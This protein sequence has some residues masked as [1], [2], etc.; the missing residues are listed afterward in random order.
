MMSR[1]ITVVALVRVGLDPAAGFTAGLGDVL[2][3]AQTP[4]FG[5]SGCRVGNSPPGAPAGQTVSSRHC[6]GILDA[7]VK[8]SGLD[9]ECEWAAVIACDLG[10]TLSI[11]MVG[12]RFGKDVGV[13]DPSRVGCG[14]GGAACL[15]AGR[16][17]SGGYGVLVSLLTSM[18]SSAS[19]RTSIWSR[20]RRIAREL[21]ASS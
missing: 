1:I 15:Y 3:R 17:A 6:V 12:Y 18:D 2:G 13:F 20:W 4:S 16:W 5:V 10:L 19:A 7:V 9:D 8:V 21:N 14:K 11:G